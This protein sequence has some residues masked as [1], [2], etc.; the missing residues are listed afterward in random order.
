MSAD[1]NFFLRNLSVVGGLA[2][3]LSAALLEKKKDIFAGIPS[4]S[5]SDK[6]KYLLLAGR[7]LLI[8]LF[9]GF[10]FNGSFTFARAIV[11]LFGLGACTMVA[12]GFRAKESA[13]FLV[14]LL[15]VF[16][17]AV[18]NFWSGQSSSVFFSRGLS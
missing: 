12:V 14:L 1:L 4:L 11:S 8:A 16:N 10:V 13:L 17:I 3:V 6:R 2:L 5:E 15:S 9:V 7:C 18:N